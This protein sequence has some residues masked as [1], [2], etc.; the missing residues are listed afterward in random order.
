[1]KLKDRISTYFFK[2]EK[3]AKIY[4]KNDIVTLQF[5]QRNNDV[6]LCG[7]NEAIEILIKNTN[8]NNYSIKYL[9]EG[10]IIHNRE[11]VLELE[12]PY[13]EFGVWEGIIDGI[14]A[15]QTSIATNAYRVVKAANGKTV[16]SMADRADHYINQERDSYA[17]EVGGIKNHSTPLASRN[18]V[19]KP[20]GSM[21]HALIQ[22]FEGDLVAACRAYHKTFPED[23]L[24]ALVDFH[25][26]VIS[27]SLACLKEFGKDLKGVRIDTSKA[28]IDKMFKDGEAQFGVTPTQVKRLREALDE[29]GGEHVKITVSSGFD[30]KR[31]ADFE[32]EQTPVDAYGVGA[33]LMSIYINFSADAT[34]IN[35][36]NVAKAGRGYLKNPNLITYQG[37]KIDE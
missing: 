12:G 8:I 15:R 26:D 23:P 3:I 14:L 13:Y 24:V 16:I 20:F 10:S 31:I 32:A 21:P 19:Q 25:N 27:D 28:M 7:I 29:N 5:F 35:G 2:T 6:K 11:V 17:I 4:H 34:R 30:E 9:P 22:M 1:M 37:E 33:S 36:K 18:S